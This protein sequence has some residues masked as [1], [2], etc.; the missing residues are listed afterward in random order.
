[1]GWG[2][3]GLFVLVTT[4]FWLRLARLRLPEEYLS[5][6]NVLALALPQLVQ[7]V[8]TQA[9]AIFLDMCVIALSLYFAFLLRFERLN[10]IQLSEYLALCCIAFVVK[11]PPLIMFGVY[12]WRSTVSLRLVYLLVKSSIAGSLCF[13]T[14]VVFWNRFDGLSRAV[15]GIDLILTVILLAA[16]RTSDWVIDAVL[17][18]TRKS[19]C[20]L[21]DGPSSRIASYFDDFATSH[22]LTEVLVLEGKQPRWRQRLLRSATRD[23]VRAIYCGPECDEAVKKH[24][25]ELAEEHGLQC[26][27]IHLFVREISYEAAARTKLAKAELVSSAGVR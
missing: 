5:R 15:F 13:V 23:A 1:M 14:A 4:L 12:R 3:L 22:E 7:S 17:H 19:G 16:V 25:A 6:T 11:L 20:V 10:S 26:Y 18:P 21:V 8:A 24:A 2:G 27:E 9:G